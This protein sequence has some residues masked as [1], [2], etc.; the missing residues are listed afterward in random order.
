MTMGRSPN[1]GSFF[2]YA[3]FTHS[4]MKDIV[5]IEKG[6]N[7]DEDERMD[8]NTYYLGNIFEIRRYMFIDW[9]SN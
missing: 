5:L 9:F 7:Y 6:E 4:I 8:D 3:D 1:K 2:L